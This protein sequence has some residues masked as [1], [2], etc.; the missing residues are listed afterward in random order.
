[1]KLSLPK[2]CQLGFSLV[3]IMI[4][5][6][7]IGGIAVLIMN[8]SKQGSNIQTST[9]A[10]SDEAE[11]AS[12]VRIILGKEAN[13]SESLKILNPAFKMDVDELDKGE[14][15]SIEL[16]Q[17][18][19]N[20]SKKIILTSDED[21]PQSKFGKL[22]I[23][24]LKLA[25]DNG[26]GS[27]YPTSLSH[28]DTGTLRITYEKPQGDGK[29]TKKMNIKLNISM[30]T[31]ALNKT[32]ATSCSKDN[33]QSVLKTADVDGHLSS[34]YVNIWDQEFEYKCPAQKAMSGEVSYHDNGTED[35]R[36]A[37]TC[38]DL[39]IDN[40]IVPRK[41]CSWTG[42]IN[43]YD[44]LI[45]FECPRGE[46]LA[47]HWSHHDNGTEDRVYSF[48]CCDYGSSSQKMKITN[49]D[50]ITPGWANYWD[51]PVNQLCP[52]GKVRIGE[53]SIHHNHYEDRIYR[54]K[55]CSVVF[56]ETE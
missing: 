40:Q 36:H 24:A 14:G 6:G 38:S 28:S 25:L 41:S 18:A 43:E 37:F 5:L 42:Q 27:N 12:V 46:I 47:G 56:E 51:Q 29:V 8:I 11:L 15:F 50:F 49:C 3:E 20:G 30:K 45:N 16:F 10:G 17:V 32:T 1:M 33:S 9:M 22:S 21:S 31:D 44:R 34:G 52:T 26:T 2:S 39:K 13:C 55:C 4:T 35:R 7:L 48:Y 54:F 23:K 19:Q 53:H